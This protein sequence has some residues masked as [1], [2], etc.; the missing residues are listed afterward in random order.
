MINIKF[1]KEELALVIKL[2]TQYREH[3]A[4]QSTNKYLYEMY[5]PRCIDCGRILEKL[6]LAKPKEEENKNGN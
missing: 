2:L 6:I 4:L 3:C 5:N 1:T